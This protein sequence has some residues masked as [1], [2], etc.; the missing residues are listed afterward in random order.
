MPSNPP[1]NASNDPPSGKDRKK[2][3]R[4]EAL[5]DSEVGEA[6]KA[7]ARRK[8]WSMTQVITSLLKLFLDEDVISP[9][10]AGEALPPRKKSKKK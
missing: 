4:I 7:K 10:D 8:G 6:A 2:K 5:V 3:T 9:E 1:S